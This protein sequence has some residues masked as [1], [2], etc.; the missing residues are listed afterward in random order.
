MTLRR[1]EEWLRNRIQR[2]SEAGK[3]SEPAKPRAAITPVSEADVQLTIMKLMSLHPAVVLLERINVGAAVFKPGSTGED[4]GADG[5]GR[6]VRF[7]AK[8][9]PDLDATIVGSYGRQLLIEVK[10]FPASRASVFSVSD[11][12]IKDQLTYVCNKRRYG[13]CAFF[14]DSHEDVKKVLDELKKNPFYMPP[15]LTWNPAFVWSESRE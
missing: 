8:G 11:Q 9:K 15:L 1:S 14:S 5:G 4:G 7:N 6:F 10:A 3:K 12:R 13:V 2:T